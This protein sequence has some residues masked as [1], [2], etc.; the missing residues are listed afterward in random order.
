[1]SLTKT[2]K[3]KLASIILVLDHDE[4]REV[5]N[6]IKIQ[7]REVEG[8]K[9]QAFRNGMRVEFEGRKGEMV[10]GTITKINRKTIIVTPDEG[11]QTWRVAPSLL[12]MS[13][14]R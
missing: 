9:V 14:T 11:Y 5:N 13:T 1:M 8:E 6:M 3:S 7:W 10:T 4:L 2:Q 12:Q